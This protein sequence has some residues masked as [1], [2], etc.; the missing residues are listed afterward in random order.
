MEEDGIVVREIST[1]A[2][3]D[4]SGEIDHEGSVTKS[5]FQQKP[6][7]NPTTEAENTRKKP[8]IRHAEKR[9][10]ST[11]RFADRVAQLSVD[12]YKRTVPADRRPAQTCI[13]TIVAHC[14]KHNG[15]RDAGEEHE[16]GVDVNG[17]GT[18]EAD[19]L[20][21]LAMGIGTKFLPES[22]LQRERE[23]EGQEG[24][25][26]RVRDMHAEV[27]ARRA[28][29]RQLTLE[30]QEDLRL[31]AEEHE[32]Q[33]ERPSN[34]VLVRSEDNSSTVCYRIRPGVTVHMYSSSAPCGNATLKRFCKMSKEKFRDDLGPDE[35]PSDA[36]DPPSGHS[37]K[38]GEFSLLVKQDSSSSSNPQTNEATSNSTTNSE[39][40]NKNTSSKMDANMDYGSKPKRTRLA[41]DRPPALRTNISKAS[42]TSQGRKTVSRRAKPW[43]ATL[44]DDWTPPG[45]TIVGFRHKGSIH[46]CSDKICRWNYLGMQ[47]SLL[48]SLMEE[49]I[50][51]ST[52]TVGRKLSGPVCRRAVCCRLD[53]RCRQPNLAIPLNNSIPLTGRTNSNKIQYRVNHP[54]IMGTSV[55]LDTGVVDTS[56]VE[57]RGQDVR[58]H[59][60]FVWAWWAGSS[61]CGVNS[62]KI[63]NTDCY[64]I[65][66][67][68]E[69][70]SGLLADL[71]AEVTAENDID[72]G[73][74]ST[75]S[76]PQVSTKSLTSA[77]LQV[78]QEASGNGSYTKNTAGYA[79]S[80][81]SY[82]NSND[83]KLT[84]EGVTPESWEN[85][86][87]TL[88]TLRSVKK[89]FSPIHEEVKDRLFAEHR[90]LSQW[91]RRCYQDI[92]TEAINTMSS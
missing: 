13:A 12:H 1:I 90:V 44:S 28:F 74:R 22:R 67:C 25:G 6:N 86:T 65:L 34:R 2:R 79:S 14:R 36:H 30:I 54:A 73:I 71:S 80:A 16:D 10:T 66:E 31:P 57:E 46:T 72:K 15:G 7:S 45:T 51:M 62:N 63:P 47:G 50:Y 42:A 78:F 27:L 23:N 70:S 35:W 85:D 92:C 61:Q 5:S 9:R 75:T 24:Y 88:N 40:K 83:T 20:W 32:R 38:L 41:G 19:V 81:A 87:N 17:T 21:V 91:R 60:S 89:R 58:F 29:R 4:I 84:P 55:Y 76:V 82:E 49:P 69:S 18:G 59:S 56:N 53:T 64:G 26:S 37:I 8:S 68:I 3:D 11:C 77:F 52:L 43:P 33:K 48:A 39:E